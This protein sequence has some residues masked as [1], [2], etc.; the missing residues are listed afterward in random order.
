MAAEAGLSLEGYWEQIIQA[1]FLDDPDPKARWRE[2]SQQLDRYTAALHALPIDRLHMQGPDVD[3][4]LTLG[5]MRRWA[6]GGGR[7][8]PSF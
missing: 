7:N 6:A 4:W 1:C 2:V 3:L 8:I 5:E